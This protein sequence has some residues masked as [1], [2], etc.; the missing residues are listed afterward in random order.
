M[1][2]RAVRPATIA[3]VLTAAASVL[4]A[5]PTPRVVAVIDATGDADGAALA[6][7]I[8]AALDPAQGLAP[9]ADPPA[10]RALYA[11]ILDE[12]A[13]VITEAR[14]ALD[15][16]QEAYNSF[17][18]ATALGAAAT[19]ETKLLAAVPRPTVTELLSNL[20]FTEGLARF[21]NDPAGTRLAF[22]EVHRLT[23]DRVLDPK[24]FFPE[25]IEAYESA[26][27]GDPGTG[28]I[29][30][31]VDGP[32]AEIWIDG[33]RAG[34]APAQIAVPAGIHFVSITGDDA[35]T[36]GARVRVDSGQTAG[37]HLTVARAEITTRLTRMRRHLLEA[38]DDAARAATIAQI[39]KT[40]GT[41]AAV[42]VV[43]A[44][45]ALGTRIWR[46]QAPGLGAVVAFTSTTP[47]QVL[48][49]LI[50]PPPP[51]D[52]HDRLPPPPPP[53]PGPPWWKKTWVRE[54][55]AIS[56][57]VLVGGI[58][59]YAATRDPGSSTLDGLGFKR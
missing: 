22:A 11:P 55:A 20:V 7:R 6:M 31:Q 52:D 5:P 21:Q 25:V 15:Q 17:N 12:D 51:P 46:D 16:A 19:G 56:A 43:R 1:P 47:A 36:T 26:G 42:V 33:A 50:P 2:R 57:I 34:A 32:G 3:V 27:R 9:L 58:A 37:L 4:A 14:A 48:E 35:V 44:G 40:L 41:D 45:D 23:P 54:V 30:V 8:G 24:H 59:T 53:P 49:P 39:A 18:N 38:P 10:A 28:M 13:A 29:D